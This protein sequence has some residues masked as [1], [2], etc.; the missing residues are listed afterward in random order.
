MDPAEDVAAAPDSWETADIDGP[1]SRLVLSARRVSSSPDLADDDQDHPPPTLSSPQHG[2]A[3]SPARDDLVDQFLREALEKPR[4]RLS[5]LRMEQDIVK[6]ISDPRQTQFEFQGLPTSYL[7]LAAHRLAQHYFLQSIAIPDNSLPDGTGSRIILR[8][9]SSECRLPAVRL[10]DIPVNLPQEE[11]SSVAKVAIKQRPQKNFHSN[12]SLSAHSSR[13]NLQKSVE[14]RKEEYN[15]A[16]AR[17]FNNSSSINAADGRPVDEVTLPNTLHR[18]TSLELN[19]SNRLGQGAEITLER[20]LTTTS[21]SSRTNR[22][23]IEKE[24]AVNRNRQNNRVA[25][26]RDRESERKDPDYDRSYDRYMQ[27]F[28]PGFG[29]NGGPYTIQPLYAPAVTY[30]TEFPQLGSAHRSPVAVEQQPRPIAQHIPGSWSAAQAPNAIGYGPPDGAMAP[31]SPG[32]AGAPVRSSVFMHAPQQYAMPSR[33]GV[34]FVHPQESMRPLAQTHQQQQSEASLRLARPRYCDAGRADRAAYSF[35]WTLDLKD[36][37]C[38]RERLGSAKR[39]PAAEEAPRVGSRISPRRPLARPQALAE[40]QSGGGV[41][42]SAAAMS[43]LQTEVLKDAISQVVAEA[44]EKNRK[45]T[46]TIELQIGLKNYDPQKDKRF[47][48]SVKLPH[49]P[50]PKMKVCMLGDAQH[51]GE[52]E[53]IGLDYM[54]VEALKKMNKNK[55]LVKKLA[56]KYHAFLASE[57]IIKQIPRLLGPGLNK[58]GKFP[59]LVSH[60]ES[61]ESKVNETKATV[62]FQLKKVLCMGVAV[63]NLSME[64]KQIQQNIQMSVNFLVS[65]LKKNWQNVRCLYIKST[66]GKPNRVF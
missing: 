13:D 48:G 16:R 28:D 29:F 5:V 57:A 8:K 3:P 25:I 7:R 26:F 56:K 22:S 58:A 64:E 35:G 66:M 23:K 63:G 30:N 32:N 21:A 52:A 1:M 60:Q 44:R 18:S 36:H 39:L 50:R 40:Q 27:R 4:E 38:G 59:T 51:V 10:A 34:P 53:K 45:F 24:P 54:D 12:H 61:L 20:S 33:P 14:E 43:K 2:P 41:Q 11:S 6:F 15:K 31:Y 47:S 55:K 9:T 46:E 42:W 62:K 37:E 49:I 65:L 19:S 17:I